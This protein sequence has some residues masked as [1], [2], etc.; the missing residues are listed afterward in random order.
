[1]ARPSF[2]GREQETGA[3]ASR[4]ARESSTFTAVRHRAR[5]PMTDDS[6]P[7]SH[8]GSQLELFGGEPAPPS[9]STPEEMREYL[10]HLLAEA[11]AAETMPWPP[12]TARLYRLLFPQLSFW[13]PEEESAQ[14]RLEFE[15]ELERLMAA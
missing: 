10:H 2:D 1:M 8:R 12:P 13:L 4:L 6:S 7:E 11:R 14:L 9:R 5:G 15:T 3:R